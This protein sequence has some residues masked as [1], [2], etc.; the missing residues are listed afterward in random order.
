MKPSTTKVL[1]ILQNDGH[2]THVTARHYNIGCVRKAISE[3]RE[4]GRSILTETRKD[5]EGQRYTRW[6]LDNSVAA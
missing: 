6:V 3:L 1:N 2:I 5:N 4:A